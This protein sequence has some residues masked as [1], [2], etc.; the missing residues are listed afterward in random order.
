ML[1]LCEGNALGLPQFYAVWIFGNNVLSCA[2]HDVGAFVNGAFTADTDKEAE[3]RLLSGEWRL[4]SGLD[5]EGNEAGLLGEVALVAHI[6]FIE[7][8][9]DAVAVVGYQFVQSFLGGAQPVGLFFQGWRV[10]A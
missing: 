9:D 7:A 10:G 5:G 1:V 4:V 8:C 6:V 3:W 2:Q